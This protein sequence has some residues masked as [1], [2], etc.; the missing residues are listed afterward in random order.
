MAEVIILPE[1]YWVFDFTRGEDPNFECPFP[2]QI[3][4]YDEVRPG[5]YTQEIFDGVR[6]L[7]IGIDI[8]AP[9]GEPIHAFGAGIIHSLGVNDE[10]GSYGPTI[11]IQHEYDGR[12]IWAL[13]GHLSMESLEMVEVG[14]AVEEG[15]IIATVGDKSV[16]GGWAPHLHF[17]LS[18]EEPLENDMPGVV[19]RDDREWALE[20]YPDPRIVLGPI[21]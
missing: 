8:G 21:Y 7:H 16:N 2:Y 5:M 12:P 4:R 6:D 10:D 9:V 17:Q 15:Q 20:K 19:S 18:W 1:D 14:K 13:Y 11:I 3:G